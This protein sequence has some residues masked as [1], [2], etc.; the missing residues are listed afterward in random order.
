LL[1]VDVSGF[2]A[3]S[4]EARRRLGSE[5]V[6]RF[7]LAISA[8]FALMMRLIIQFEG[9][10]DCFAG[11]AVLVVFEAKDDRFPR[12]SGE[13]PSQ[14]G[15]H[16]L[17]ESTASQCG[18]VGLEEAMRR[19]LECAMAVHSRLDGFRYEP[20]DPPLRMHSALAA[21]MQAA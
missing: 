21:G 14:G 12:K 17:S 5:G 9:D 8:F 20:E 2:T 6:E 19:A 18:D 4:E 15:S 7:S 13:C 3:L 1:I 10:V 11:D 16:V